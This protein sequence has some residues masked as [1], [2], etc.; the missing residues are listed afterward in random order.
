MFVNLL[1]AS[2]RWQFDVRAI[3]SFW[4]DPRLRC[5]SWLSSARCHCRGGSSELT[6][7]LDKWWHSVKFTAFFNQPHSNN[8]RGWGQSRGKTVPWTG[9]SPGETTAGTKTNYHI[10]QWKH[11]SL[12][13]GWQWS[14]C[15]GLTCWCRNRMVNR[16]AMV[17]FC[18][19]SHTLLATLKAKLRLE[20]KCKSAFNLLSVGGP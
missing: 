18:L 14:V 17:S 3:E 5:L 13:T 12:L 10:Q 8:G 20:C 4:D 2:L 7:R 1:T 15:P 19:N 11:V 9:D 6:T 16:V